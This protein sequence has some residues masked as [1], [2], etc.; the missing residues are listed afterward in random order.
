MAELPEPVQMELWIVEYKGR[1]F[2]W[3]G[4]PLVQGLSFVHDYGRHGIDAR[5][6]SLERFHV[7]W[8]MEP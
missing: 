2:R 7:Y 6:M 1:R 3:Q 8:Q 5:D 4:F